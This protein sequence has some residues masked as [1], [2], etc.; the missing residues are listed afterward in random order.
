MED[1]CHGCNHRNIKTRSFERKSFIDSLKIL[2][3]TLQVFCDLHCFTPFPRPLLWLPEDSPETKGVLLGAHKLQL[4]SRNQFGGLKWHAT[5]FQAFL[6]VFFF[7]PAIEL[8]LSL[9]LLPW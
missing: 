5:G 3:V 1:P 8:T 2:K 4:L 7:N 9:G 6:N